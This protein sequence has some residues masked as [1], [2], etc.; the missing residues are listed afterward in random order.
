KGPVAESSA[1]LRD[2]SSADAAHSGRCRTCEEVSQ[3][4][5]RGGQGFARRGVRPAGRAGAGSRGTG[6][7]AADVERDRSAEISGRGDA[8]LW[9]AERRGDRRGAARVGA[10]G[11]A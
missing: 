6:R 8:V 1:L 3:T 9:R 11:D 7:S 2:G 4:R 10:Y 5:R